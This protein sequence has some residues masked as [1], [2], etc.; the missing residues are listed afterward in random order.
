MSPQRL[1]SRRRLSAVALIILAGATYPAGPIDAQSISRLMP[2]YQP[3]MRKAPIDGVTGL[4]ISPDLVDRLTPDPLG[5]F[6]A[7]SDFPAFGSSVLPHTPPFW[8]PHRAT[9]SKQPLHFEN[10]D[11][12]MPPP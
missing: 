10:P 5:R 4:R 6:S 9:I 8:G 11:L 1:L 7:G 2:V 12:A 3:M